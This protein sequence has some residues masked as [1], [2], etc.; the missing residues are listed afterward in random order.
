LLLDR[1][2]TLAER[3]L[4]SWRPNAQEQGIRS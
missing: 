2:V 3:R 1:L 4:M